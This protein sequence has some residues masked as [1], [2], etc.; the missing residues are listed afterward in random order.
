M[1]VAQPNAPSYRFLHTAVWTGTN[2]VV[3][4][5]ARYCGGCG[6]S[7]LCSDNSHVMGDGAVFNPTSGTW[8]YISVSGANAPGTRSGQT[9]V[10]TGSQMIVWGGQ[11]TTSLGNGAILSP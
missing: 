5:G 4:G 8:S 7:A 2:M 1:G 6:P 11:R 9:A 3:W 10:W